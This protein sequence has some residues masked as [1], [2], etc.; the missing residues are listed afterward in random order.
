MT[1]HLGKYQ[2]VIILAPVEIP[3]PGLFFFIEE[4]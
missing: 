1:T 4:L 2:S 3:A